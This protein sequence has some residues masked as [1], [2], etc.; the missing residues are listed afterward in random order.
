VRKTRET[1]VVNTT[2]LSDASVVGNISSENMQS[3]QLADNDNVNDEKI[4]KNDDDITLS[5]VKNNKENDEKIDNDDITLSEA[6]KTS[7]K[8]GG[9]VTDNTTETKQEA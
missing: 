8:E 4:D 5:E 1:N 6:E 3:E 9:T 7:E 2:P